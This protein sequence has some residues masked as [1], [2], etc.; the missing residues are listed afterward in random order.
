MDSAAFD[1]G[2]FFRFGLARAGARTA[3]PAIFSSDYDW[4]YRRRLCGRLFPLPGQRRVQA[5]VQSNFTGMAALLGGNGKQSTS[6]S[7]A[8]S[9]DTTRTNRLGVHLSSPGVDRVEE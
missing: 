2:G 5:G 8:R 4:V 1:A 6:S 7:R 3:E 9:Y